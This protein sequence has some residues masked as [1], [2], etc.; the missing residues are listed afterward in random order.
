ME[1]RIICLAHGN[2][3]YPTI[4][5]GDTLIVKRGVSDIDINQIVLYKDD[6]NTLF[7]HR[8]VD[9]F[10]CSGVPIIVTKGDNCLYYDKP[11]E[12]V[13]VRGMV[14]EIKRRNEL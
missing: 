12:I 2:S 11:V 4:C 9:F 6:N 7:V 13:K 8:I 5:H 14:V 10:Y 1:D 3:M